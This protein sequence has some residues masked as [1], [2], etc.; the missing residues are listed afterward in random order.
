M[1]LAVAVSTQHD[2]LLLGFFQGF[3][4]HTGTQQTVNFNV[5][6]V[7]NHVVKVER[8]RV[9]LPALLAG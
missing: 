1:Q 3:F 6:G 4:K 2:A 7:A 9:V 8:C 5:V